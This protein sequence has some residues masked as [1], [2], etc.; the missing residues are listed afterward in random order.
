V[1]LDGL[2]IDLRA[3]AVRREGD[4]VHLT[5]IEFKLLG[6][7]TQNRGRLLTH[8]ALLQHVWGTA[9]I[10]ARQTLRVRIANL[11]R[12]IEPADGERLIHTDHGSATALRTCILRAQ[13]GDSLRK[14]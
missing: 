6:V 7:L 13:D 11:R 14:K 10:D 3:R 5:P 2:D 12:K 1:E 8:N 4:E 9:Y